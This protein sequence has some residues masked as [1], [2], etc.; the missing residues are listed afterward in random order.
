[1]KILGL[2]TSCDETAA[3]IVEDGRRIISN[4]VSS[5]EGLHVQTGGVIPEVAA[6]EQLRYMLPVI[7]KATAGTPYDAIAV[8]YG[9][10]LIGSLL[11]GV[12][13]AKALAYAQK[14]PLIPVNHLV[15][16]IYANWLLPEEP[17]LPAVVLIASGAH[18][19]IV[20]MVGHGKFEYLGGTRDDAAGEAFDKAA[21]LLGLPYPGGP[22]IDR[23]AK[24]GTAGKIKLPRP[25]L[26]D[27]SHDLSFAGLKTAL[28]VLSDKEKLNVPDAAA[29]V[30]EAI[31]DVLVEKTL[32]AAKEKKVSSIL[33]G[34]GVVANLRLREKLRER[35]AGELFIPE[36]KLST[37]NAAM[38]AAAAFYN[39][40]PVNPLTLQADSSLSLQS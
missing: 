20:L 3:A 7:E 1:M 25:M 2:E 17:R 13:T 4:V 27:Q 38:I 16:H 10:G 39:N 15:G 23:E 19:D 30:Q 8:T 34:G 36:V 28:R 35:W 31:T 12:E 9:P 22:A 32:R 21:R 24:Q 37:D 14:L 26:D 33:L 29:E 18:S 40:D 6:R 11:I 5:S